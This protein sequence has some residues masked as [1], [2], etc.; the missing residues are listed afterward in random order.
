MGAF[1][2]FLIVAAPVAALAMFM[3][4]QQREDVQQRQDAQ[5]LRQDRV[6]S[7]V[8]QDFARLTG[9]K[10]RAEVAAQRIEEI[11]KKIAQKD[12]VVEAIAAETTEQKVETK[13]A[14]DA[15]AVGQK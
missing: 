9:D 15:W 10:K 6:Q 4:I 14:L 11:D 12:A 13:S 2:K 8:D 7:Q 3:F 5:I 1:F